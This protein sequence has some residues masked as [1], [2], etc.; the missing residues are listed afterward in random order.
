MFVWKVKF[1]SIYILELNY[2]FCFFVCSFCRNE[3]KITAVHQLKYATDE[4]FKLICMS[5]PEIRRLRK[6]YDKYYKFNYLSKIKRLLQ[7]PVKRD[8]VS[9]IIFRLL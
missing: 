3:L 9:F 7:N 5:R 2:K 1:L 4:D 6:F 8:E